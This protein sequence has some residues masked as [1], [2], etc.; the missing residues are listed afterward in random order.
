MKKTLAL[1]L[2]ILVTNICSAATIIKKI[3][4]VSAENFYG[5]VASQIG[6]KYV[7]VTSILDNPNGDPHLFSTS[8]KISI[9]ITNAQII[10]FN[11]VSYDTWMSNLI[12]SQP[13]NKK[14]AIINVGR[15]MGVKDGANPHIWYQPNTFPTFAKT[16][17]EKLIQ[18]ENSPEATA[19]FNKNLKRFLNDNLAVQKK[20]T[21]LKQKYQGIPVTATE[22][23]FGYMADAIGLKM[24]GLDFQWKIMN[25][26]EPTPQMLGQYE[27]DITSHKVKV[28]FYNDQVTDPTTHNILNLAKKSDIPII[29]VSETM[30]THDTV[31]EW[32]LAEL[33]DTQKALEL[34]KK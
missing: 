19:Y 9:A 13:N 26:A 25:D 33:N 32:I 12:N 18:I 3:N 10:I 4:V 34:V 17:T 11:G 14:L 1:T 15:L 30:P 6:G 31:N 7:N 16:M 2:I 23:V 24:E 8:P 20:I 29:G 5:S 27:N 21:E 28:L 22:P